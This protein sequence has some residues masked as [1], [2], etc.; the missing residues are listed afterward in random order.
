L[1]R[2]FGY[3][4]LIMYNVLERTEI[5][6]G[7]RYRWCKY[8]PINSLLFYAL[9]ALKI[10]RTEVSYWLD[11]VESHCTWCSVCC[12][13]EQFRCLVWLLLWDSGVCTAARCGCYCLTGL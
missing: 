6:C 10:S 3:V 12:V 2:L 9:D 11:T 13:T 5:G 1:C 8:L 4:L 7:G